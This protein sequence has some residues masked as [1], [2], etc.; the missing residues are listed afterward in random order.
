[1]SWSRVVVVLAL[2][3]G[4]L[5]ACAGEKRPP[6]EPVAPP[7]ANGTAKPEPVVPW[8][9]TPW[10]GKPGPGWKDYEKLVN[11]QK[12]EEASKRVE[13]M[14]AE[15]RAEGQMEEL[16]RALIRYT[17]LRISLH[18]YETAVRFLKEQEWPDDLLSRVALN[19]FYGQALTTYAQAY[20][21]EIGQREKV[22]SK[23]TVDLKAWTMEQIHA[24]AAR[25]YGEVWKH[26]EELS[27]QPVE[28]LSEVLE[29]N[30]Y[31]KD[32]R[33][34]LRDA[35]SYLLVDLL[36]NTQGWRPEQSNEIFALDLAALL[37]KAPAM[38]VADQGVHPLMRIASVLT[39]LEG[40]HAGRQEKGAAFEAR[41]ARLQALHGSFTQ[42]PDRE[43]IRKDLEGRL[44]GIRDHEWWS[45]GMAQLSSFV[46]AEG[47]ADALI[48]ARAIA[49]EGRAAYPD[50]V[51]GQRC[52]HL[53]KAIE[54]PAFT[55]EGMASD[56]PGK[57]SLLLQHKNLGKIHFRAFTLNLQEIIARSDDYNLL[58]QYQE[59]EK[60]ARG[61][62]AA[63]WAV[64]LPATPDFK[65][66]KTFVVPPLKGPGAYAVVASAKADFSTTTSCWWSSTW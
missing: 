10:T 36:S 40:W 33:P 38:E 28:A 5:L 27:G 9:V 61:K 62:R 20:G 12:Y 57:K 18:G 49:E 59:L 25:A 31:P 54:V 34:T 39:D 66:H 65:L 8:K 42:A 46:Q 58:P 55:L 26:R 1:M 37:G 47:S 2:S 21:W 24:E 29:K 16:T 3:V 19:L 50:S 23:G 22:E 44:P 41:L 64:D 17:Q 63:E 4:L 14:I 32:I 56:G 11:E 30:S 6:V 53:V 48:K 35:V 13:A 51:G 43:R 60:I 15:A 45:V 7:A 52:L